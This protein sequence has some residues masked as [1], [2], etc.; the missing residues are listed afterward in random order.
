ME[1]TGEKE[2]TKEQLVMGLDDTKTMGYSWGE[3][4]KKAKERRCLIDGLHVCFQRS[5]WIKSSNMYSLDN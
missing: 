1:H 5:E 4:E 2:N 3:L